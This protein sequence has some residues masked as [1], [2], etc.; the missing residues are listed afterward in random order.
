MPSLPD[1]PDQPREDGAPSD[2]SAA[3]R[4]LPWQGYWEQPGFG[5]QEMRNLRLRM[6]KGTIAGAGVDCVAPFMFVGTYTSAGVVTMVKQYVGRHAVKYDGVYDGEG[7][8]R[9][10]W[11]IDGTTIGPFLLVL[12]RS[13]DAADSPIQSL[14]R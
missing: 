14:N 12:E 2:R 6:S 4:S 13:T 7:T 11:S 10:W 5:R 1:E 3:D 9:G 8:I